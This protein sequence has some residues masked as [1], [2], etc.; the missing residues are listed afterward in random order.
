MPHLIF[1]SKFSKNQQVLYALQTK[2]L[3]FNY[4]FVCWSVGDMRAR[5]R[6]SNIKNNNREKAR[7][8]ERQE[9]DRR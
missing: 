8:R 6:D 4:V 7:E 3:L 9:R 5:E 2:L 1:Q